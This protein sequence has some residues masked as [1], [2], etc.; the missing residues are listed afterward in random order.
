[1]EGGTRG[2]ERAG[3]CGGSAGFVRT[4]LPISTIAHVLLWGPLVLPGAEPLPKPPDPIVVEIVSADELREASKSA[5]PEASKPEEPGEAAKPQAPAEA[6]VPEPSQRAEPPPSAPPRQEP[7]RPPRR[8]EPTSRPAAEPVRTASAAPT[9]PAASTPEQPR[10]WGTWFDTALSSPLVTANAG[11]DVAASAANLA[12][13]D[14]AA[15]K[16]H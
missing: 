14:I 9:V 13:E 6:N 15:F 3:N 7:P 2:E 1:E 10:P 4:A 12:R 16:A 11:S 5:V 8:H